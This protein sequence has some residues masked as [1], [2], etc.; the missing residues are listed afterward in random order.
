[1]RNALAVQWLL[2]RRSP[3]GVLGTLVIVGGTLAVLGGITAALAAGDPQVTARLGPDA[4]R[5][6]AGL[7]AAAAQVGAAGGLVGAGTVLAWFFAREFTD[8]TVAGLYALPIRR[9]TLALAKLVVFGAWGV[10]LALAVTIGVLGLGVALGYGMPD[11]ADVERCLRVLGLGL[12]T[13]LV[14]V[15]VAWLASVTRSLLAGVAGTVGLVVVGQVGMLAGAGA[16]VPPAAPALWA[17]GV[18]DVGMPHLLLTCVVAVV[19]G[20]LTC[21]HWERMELR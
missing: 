6:W 1:M 4:T 16:W 5:D 18:A 3:V 8:D 11:G 2:L 15:P 17:T 7:L 19:F 10:L 9:G 20:W 12:L 13:P 21:R 14:A